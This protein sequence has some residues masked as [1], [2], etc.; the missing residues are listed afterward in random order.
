MSNA[1][2]PDPEPVNSA[3]VDIIQAAQADGTKGPLDLDA[4][5]EQA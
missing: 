4:L 2:P 3:L 5:M 1:E